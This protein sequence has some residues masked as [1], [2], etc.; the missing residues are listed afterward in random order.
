MI[1]E[2]ELQ[3]V[4]LRSDFKVDSVLVV[5]FLVEWMNSKEERKKML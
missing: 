5:D 4:D 1:V 2:E 3:R